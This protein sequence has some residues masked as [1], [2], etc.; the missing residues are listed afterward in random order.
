MSSEPNLGSYLSVL[1]R[2]SSPVFSRLCIPST[3][4]PAVLLIICSC[5]ISL[6]KIVLVQLFHLFR[7]CIGGTVFYTPDVFSVFGKAPFHCMA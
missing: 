1:I 3:I 4:P 6:F 5:S 2:F 7:R